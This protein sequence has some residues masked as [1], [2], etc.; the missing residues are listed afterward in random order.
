MPSSIPAGT[1]V[2]ETHFR[3][4][5]DG[6]WED[7]TTADLF[8]GKTV[9]VFGLPGAFTPTCSSSHVPR[10]NELQPRFAA[11]GV[12]AILCVS[13]N[14]A[15]VM[16]A[17]QADQRAD[18]LTFVPDGNGTFTEAMGM[19]VDKA[20]LGFGRRSWRYSMLVRDGEVV[21]SFVEP[22]VPGDPFEV[23]DAETM[24]AF[25]APDAAPEPD[26]MMLVKLGCPH[27]ALAET[28]LTKAGLPFEAVEASPRM[29][30]AVSETTT[31]PRIFINGELIGG[32]VELASWLDAR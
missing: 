32:A 28:T 6:D 21:T 31:T 1:R 11:L 8:A 10:Y 18:R 29:L 23:S 9:V 24:L 19:L 20:D 12:D 15:F 17:W 26:I 4:R 2:P 22:D 30:R 5:V 3:F 25:L 13:V 7:V 14:D 16:N 27:C